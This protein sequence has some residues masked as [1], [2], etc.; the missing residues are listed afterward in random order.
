MATVG[1]KKTASFQ[2]VIYALFTQGVK[3]FVC[4]V[5]PVFLGMAEPASAEA[6]LR[7][8]ELSFEEL[9]QLEVIFQQEVETA[10]K[11]VQSLGSVPAAMSFIS[12]EDIRRSGARSIP[13][14]LRMAPGIQASR[15]DTGRWAVGSRGLNGR[16]SNKLQVVYD[17]K[18][19]Y[20]PM[21]SGV[22]WEGQDFF[23]DDLKSIEV[24][25]GPGGSIW[26]ANAVNG[27]INISS[28]HARDTQGWLLRVGVGTE[29][30]FEQGLRY[31]GKLNDNVFFRVFGQYSETAAL[32]P[33]P[34]KGV[35]LPVLPSPDL[36]EVGDLYSGLVGV[37][38]DG[39]EGDIDF[40][41]QGEF[42][43]NSMNGLYLTPTYEQFYPP[44][45][46]DI[47]NPAALQRFDK[48]ESRFQNIN[49]SGRWTKKLSEVQSMEV[50]ANL[51]RQ[52]ATLTGLKSVA[53]LFDVEFRHYFQANERHDIIWGAGFSAVSQRN[54]S[55]PILSFDP[56]ESLDTVG[57]LFFQDEITLIADLLFLT[58]GSKFEFNDTTGFE[59]QPNAR[60]LYTVNDFHSI[61]GSVARAVR[62]PSLLG[63]AT[64]DGLAIFVISPP[65]PPSGIRLPVAYLFQGDADGD[66]ED[67]YAFEVGY[68]SQP[69]EEFFFDVALFYNIYDN[70]RG[71]SVP[72]L[73]K[74]YLYPAYGPLYA[75]VDSHFTNG[76]SAVSYGGELAFS[77]Q[78]LPWWKLKGH[79][80]YLYLDYD[81]SKLANIYRDMD[82]SP[83][84][85]VSLQS[86]MDLPY[87]FELD[88]WLR[89][90]SAIKDDESYI[91]IE[92]PAY[93]TM[94]VRLGWRP[95]EQWEFSVTGQNLLEPG[96][97]EMV[98]DLFLLPAAEVPRTFYFQAVYRF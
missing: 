38:I 25:R 22:F 85:Q 90:S 20:N 79:Y 67:L 74:S 87:D 47:N 1:V 49:L 12:A 60:L 94:D 5:M 55:T 88:L 6:T 82:L 50:Q 42:S 13:E 53:N 76:V 15:I 28:K 35:S 92:V 58:I 83:V 51:V 57:S 48:E 24:V 80:S 32:E 16:F 70:L 37:R 10:S 29:G 17:G 97:L 66:S 36:P 33:E 86:S 44:L 65:L 52:Q 30:E 4:L 93:T 71:G 41:L 2:R 75:A 18:K 31:G 64:E 89:Y 78:A 62:T 61:W 34:G 26:G 56:D 27:V 54:D 8:E 95:T 69:T 43:Q 3:L 77:Y 73:A 45:G 40:T 59:V 84:H 9:F 81:E 11:K 98:T 39:S 14:A 19:I 96:H 21:F 7:L 63:R 91:S 23:M 72:D 46:Y 68:R